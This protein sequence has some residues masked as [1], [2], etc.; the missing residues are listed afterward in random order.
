[1]KSIDYLFI[2]CYK[3]A[4]LTSSWAVKERAVGILATG[5]Y[6]YVAPILIST[7]NS[8]NYILFIAPLILLFCICI[9]K[10]DDEV[11]LKI[12][13][14]KYNRSKALH[15]IIFWLLGAFITLGTL[16]LSPLS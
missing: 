6:L 3:D 13:K 10:Y 16:Y 2:C 11:K 9:Y 14:K 7:I 1:L 8:L 15:G 4:Q 12:L 5:L